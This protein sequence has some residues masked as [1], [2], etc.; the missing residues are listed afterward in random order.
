MEKKTKNLIIEV[1][2]GIV[3]FTGAA[4]A[5]AGFFCPRGEVFAGLLLGMGLALA[6]FL[7]MAVVLE[8]AMKTED[9]KLVQKRS[10]ISAVVRYV[11][12]A[13]ILV[14]VIIWFSDRINPVA[15][16]I[17]VLGLKAGAYLQPVIHKITDRGEGAE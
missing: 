5:A 3:I 15:V 10:V 9:P 13:A 11:L 7:S 4:M 2:A 12:L 14:A 16:V 6:M 8:R 17:G 1:S